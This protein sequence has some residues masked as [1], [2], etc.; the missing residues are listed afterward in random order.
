MCADQICSI[1]F[2]YTG[3]CDTCLPNAS[4][5]GSLCECDTPLVWNPYDELCDNCPDPCGTCTRYTFGGCTSCNTGY[6]DSYGACDLSCPTGWEISGSLCVQD[7][8]FDADTHI[9][10]LTIT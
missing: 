7:G 9:F 1:C 6:Y 8:S 4:L 2:D 5:V 10:S 3:I